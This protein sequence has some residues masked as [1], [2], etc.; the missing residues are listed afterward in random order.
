MS[1]GSS[2]KSCT[3]GFVATINATLVTALTHGARELAAP[4]LETEVI[5][6]EKCKDL[7]QCQLI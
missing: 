4:G 2:E 3:L 7:I 5:V 6:K 1:R